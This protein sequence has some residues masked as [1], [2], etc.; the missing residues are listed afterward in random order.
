MGPEDSWGVSG[1]SCWR[2]LFF[3]E[4]VLSGLEMEPC[5]HLGELRPRTRS[6]M[7]VCL[8][9]AGTHKFQPAFPRLVSP[10][11]ALLGKGSSRGIPKLISY[12]HPI[13][14][15]PRLIFLAVAPLASELF[16]S[17]GRHRMS[18]SQVEALGTNF[19]EEAQVFF[20]TLSLLIFACSKAVA[21]K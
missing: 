21:G 2:A 4:K 15:S 9:F 1:G 18:P 3:P 12:C 6:H 16:I 20:L 13:S 19:R 7:T 5:A 17:L 14:F 8:S 11:A 10:V